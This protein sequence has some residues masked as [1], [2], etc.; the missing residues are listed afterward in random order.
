MGFWGK[1]LYQNDTALDVKDQFEELLRQG[2]NVEQIT[3]HLIAKSACLL[4][5]PNE[6]VFFWL[7]LADT[8]WN[9]GVLVSPVKE[10]ALQCIDKAKN[11][12]FLLLTQLDQTMLD[13]LREKLLSP[14]PLP[15]MHKQRKLYRCSWSIGDVYA[16]RLES[17]L[18]KEKGL[19]RRYL[20]IQKVDERIWSPGHIVPIVYVKITENDSIP[21]SMEEYNQLEYVQTWFTKFEER[22]LPIDFRRPKEDIAEKE[23]LHYEVDDFGFLPQYRMCLVSTSQKEI[24]KTLEY[25]G[26][27]AGSMPP[28]KEFIPHIKTNIVSE[29]WGKH[30]STFERAMIQKYCNYNRRELSIYRESHN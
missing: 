20:L 9:C 27:F 2:N 22:F 24:P 6:T 19:Y 11:A 21:I 18:A 12:G 25:L 26:N 16:Y 8:Q 5:D 3:E 10:K 7:A 15:Q 30:S 23:K 17:D 1:G 28:K 13:K 29:T 4:N 14:F